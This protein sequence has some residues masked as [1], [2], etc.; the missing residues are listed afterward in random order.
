MTKLIVKV[1]SQPVP[2]LM[3]IADDHAP[4]HHALLLAVGW[5][6]PWL[7]W[8][9]RRQLHRPGYV[10]AWVEILFHSVSCPTSKLWLAFVRHLLVTGQVIPYMEATSVEASRRS[11]IKDRK[12][13]TWK[14]DAFST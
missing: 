3:A 10:A 6:F 9:T 2:A 7:M 14:C 1:S 11:R 12:S 5:W 13:T 4:E 8:G